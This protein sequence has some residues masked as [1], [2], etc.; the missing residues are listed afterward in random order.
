MYA[1]VSAESSPVTALPTST[2]TL[3]LANARVLYTP[4]TALLLY[5]WTTIAVLAYAD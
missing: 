5:I 4:V 3:L 1:N 2:L